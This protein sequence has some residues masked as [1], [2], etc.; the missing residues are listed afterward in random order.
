MPERHE[1]FAW[2]G[3]SRRSLQAKSDRPGKKFLLS[4]YCLRVSAVKIFTYL[5][6][7]TGIIGSFH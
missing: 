5:S 3:L 2:A 4:A 6:Q 1:A 7:T